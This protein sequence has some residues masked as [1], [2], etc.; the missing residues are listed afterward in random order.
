MSFKTI[1]PCYQIINKATGLSHLLT[2]KALLIFQS[3]PNYQLDYTIVEGKYV[4]DKNGKIRRVDKEDQPQP[5]LSTYAL[6]INVE[7][8]ANTTE[9][10]RGRKP[11]DPSFVSSVE[12]N[13][14]EFNP[15][16]VNNTNES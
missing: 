11:K 2:E 12:N 10:R 6:D 16:L 15:N 14:I 13:T 1:Q 7:N 3:T 8:E 5:K 4:Y 9:S